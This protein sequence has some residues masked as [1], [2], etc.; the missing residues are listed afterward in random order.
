MTDYNAVVT[1]D[2]GNIESLRAD[3]ALLAPD[4]A[5]ALEPGCLTWLA[6]NAEGFTSR[7]ILWPDRRRAALAADTGS[8]WGEWDAIARRI[9]LANGDE[10]NVLGGVGE[11]A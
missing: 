2:A 6:E 4:Q 9:T 1:V 8:C 7:L 5:A 3:L 10:I 11:D